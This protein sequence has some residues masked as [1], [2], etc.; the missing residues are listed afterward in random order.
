PTC[1]ASAA[2]GAAK[3][4]PAITAMNRLRPSELR[5]GSLPIGSVIG[6]PMEN[7]RIAGSLAETKPPLAPKS[8]VGK[9]PKVGAPPR[10]SVSNDIAAARTI[11]QPGI[12][13][14]DSDSLEEGATESNLPPAGARVAAFMH[15]RAFRV[16]PDGRNVMNKSRSTRLRQALFSLPF[17]LLFL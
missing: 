16:I 9:C 10:P 13:L 4:P 7:A 17:G 14:E 12:D 15:A 3:R 11:S 5:S 8:A 6:P 2:S 1:C